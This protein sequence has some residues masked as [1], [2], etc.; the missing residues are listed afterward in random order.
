MCARNYGEI[1]S[2]NIQ[3]KA[4]KS[5]LTIAR[6]RPVRQGR[7]GVA[8]LATAQRTRM[9]RGPSTLPYEEDARA[10]VDMNVVGTGSGRLIEVQGTGEGATFSA[11]ELT[12]LTSLALDGIATLTALQREAVESA[13]VKWPL[14]GT[15]GNGD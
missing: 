15:L 5:D 11:D 13:G 1:G 12:E 6:R 3:G 4:N 14:L 2:S 8:D 7:A 9:A 10:D